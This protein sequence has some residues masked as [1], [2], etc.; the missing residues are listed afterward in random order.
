VAPNVNHVKAAIMAAFGIA[1]EF[2]KIRM[3]QEKLDKMIEGKTKILSGLLEEL[4]IDK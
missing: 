4:S 3:E 2:F 1:D